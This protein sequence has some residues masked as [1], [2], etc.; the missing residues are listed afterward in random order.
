MASATVSVS[1]GGQYVPGLLAEQSSGP[2][3]PQ[4]HEYTPSRGN[5]SVFN[6]SNLLTDDNLSAQTGGTYNGLGILFPTGLQFP[7]WQQP[8]DLHGTGRFTNPVNINNPAQAALI[9][10][11]RYT[12][13]A[14]QHKWPAYRNYQNSYATGLYANT[15][16]RFLLPGYTRRYDVDEPEETI[17]EPAYARSDLDAIFGA[18]EN[19]VLHLAQSDQDI[20]GLSGRVR[21]LA[22][23]NFDGTDVAAAERRG[24]F[25]TDSWDLKSF[26]ITNYNS[27]AAPNSARTW[28][29]PTNGTFP[30]A[31]SV[32]RAPVLQLLRGD[33][34]GL[35]NP[36]YAT[37]LNMRKLSINHLCDFDYPASAQPNVIFRPLTPHPTNLDCAAN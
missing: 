21:D 2:G 5:F 29:F 33:T 3:L 8:L 28:E 12:Q 20:L 24:R 26:G 1:L 34:T 36:T 27:G 31:L 25:T 13:N 10:K 7:A 16:T 37:N 18:G 19:A 22:P 4:P 23:N 32:F 17:L 30:P 6:P 9:G 11:Q 15:N 35:T 14:G